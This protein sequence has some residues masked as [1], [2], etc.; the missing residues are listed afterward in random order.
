MKISKT[1]YQSVEMD[2]KLILIELCSQTL[3]SRCFGRLTWCQLN[4]IVFSSFLTICLLIFQCENVSATEIQLDRVELLNQTYMEGFYNLSEF[5]VTKF[6]RTSYVWNAEV[7]MFSD[8]DDKLKLEVTFH[9]NR[10][11]NNQYNKSPMQIS[12]DTLCNIAEKYYRKFIM[13]DIKDISNFPQ[14]KAGEPVCPIVK[15]CILS[16]YNFEYFFY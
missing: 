1:R 2:Y 4:M 3:C 10:L 5:R 15:V 12:K 8:I 16:K 11:N 9:H 14:L 7:E 6:N 13:N